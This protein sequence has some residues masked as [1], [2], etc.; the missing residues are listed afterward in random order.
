MPMGETHH[1]AQTLKPAESDPR[2][3]DTGHTF[4]TV[5]KCVSR[6]YGI[7]SAAGSK[8]KQGVLA[9]KRLPGHCTF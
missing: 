6:P 3:L 8:R 5:R 4:F 2:I 1:I 7:R 9:D